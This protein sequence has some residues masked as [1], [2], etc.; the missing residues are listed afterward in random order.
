MSKRKETDQNKKITFKDTHLKTRKIQ[1]GHALDIYIYKG[2]GCKIHFGHPQNEIYKI[3]LRLL[4]N[5]A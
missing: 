1:V 2:Q 3:R 5:L 4:V